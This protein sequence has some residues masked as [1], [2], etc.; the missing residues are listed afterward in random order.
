MR[1]NVLSTFVAFVMS[2]LMLLVFLVVSFVFVDRTFFADDPIFDFSVTSDDASLQQDDKGQESATDKK[3]FTMT[4]DAVSQ[5]TPVPVR[6]NDTTARYIQMLDYR[7]KSEQAA[8]TI[9]VTEGYSVVILDQVGDQFLTQI[10]PEIKALGQPNITIADQSGHTT[11]YGAQT[12]Q[13]QQMIQQYL[14]DTYYLDTF[15][16]VS[17]PLGGRG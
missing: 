1:I 5:V 15:L 7:R 9:A 11:V 16:T 13:E 4:R 12:A 14:R 8:P 2:T 6:R 17:S 10:L 3:Q